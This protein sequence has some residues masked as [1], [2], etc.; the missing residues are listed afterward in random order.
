MLA[1]VRRMQEGG[2]CL[3]AC[4]CNGRIAFS[5]ALELAEA[6]LVGTAL[7]RKRDEGV[8]S[9]SRAMAEHAQLP[10]SVGV[11]G[12]AALTLAGNH[13]GDFISSLRPVLDEGDVWVGSSTGADEE[14]C[15]TV[16]DSGWPELVDE[17]EGPLCRDKS[18]WRVPFRDSAHRG[19]RVGPCVDGVA[20]YMERVVVF[21]SIV[22]LVNVVSVHCEERR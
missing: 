2:G 18:R 16:N 21:M 17:F 6:G 14:G 3:P 20:E 12:A 4:A 1:S 15:S 22:L 8:L 7:T 19:V 9:V 10:G 11:E 5:C 13:P